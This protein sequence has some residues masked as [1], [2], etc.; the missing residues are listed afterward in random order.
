MFTYSVSNFTRTRTRKALF[1]MLCASWIT[2]AVLMLTSCGALA[3]LDTLDLKLDKVDAAVATVQAAS[4][5][6]GEKGR[7]LAQKAQ[8][9]GTAVRAADTNKDGSIKGIPEW[10]TLINLLGNVLLGFGQIGTK[11]DIAQTQQVATTA[12]T[13]ATAA[14][15]TANVNTAKIDG[16]ATELADLWTGHVENAAKI[17]AKNPA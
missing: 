9:V 10:L 5:A 14:A 13:T 4:A 16:H 2:L 1:A 3:K 6:L 7:D 17:A 15:A 11:K 12:N 8:D